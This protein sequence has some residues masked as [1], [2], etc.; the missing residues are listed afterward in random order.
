[1]RVFFSFFFQEWFDFSNLSL[2]DDERTSKY[3]ARKPFQVNLLLDCKYALI[4]NVKTYND[5]VA[6]SEDQ[7][8]DDGQAE[9]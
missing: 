6:S 9:Y 4:S 8:A 1:M 5:A 2:F 7:E 3:L